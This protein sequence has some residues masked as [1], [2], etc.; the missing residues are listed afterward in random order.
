MENTST[1]PVQVDAEDEFPM[2][3][4]SAGHYTRKIGKH[5]FE[6]YKTESQID[7]AQGRPVGHSEWFAAVD[8]EVVA[9]G[10]NNKS[11]KKVLITYAA[12]AEANAV[13]T[14]KRDAAR[15]VF[16][17]VFGEEASLPVQVQKAL[18][19]AYGELVDV[20][21]VEKPVKKV[22]SKK[23]ASKP[24]PEPVTEAAPEPVAELVA[25]E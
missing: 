12:R 11:V 8:G 24:E 5:T 1:A 7:G 14:E 17:E 15:L 23:K 18:E 4:V 3:R 22:A 10:R 25:S 21:P 19:R 2:T 20:L 6:T 13:I 16:T 9:T